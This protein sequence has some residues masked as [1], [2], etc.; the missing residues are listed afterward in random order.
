MFVR[1]KDV[2]PRK[3]NDLVLERVMLPRNESRGKNVEAVHWTLQP[4]GV[5]TI[6]LVERREGAFYVISGRGLLQSKGGQATRGVTLYSDMAFWFAKGEFVMSNKGE[7]EMRIIM[8]TSTVD[9]DHYEFTRPRMQY[10]HSAPLRLQAGYVARAM[11][12]TQEIATCGGL[13]TH[14]MEVETLS[15]NYEAAIHIDPEEVLYVL[16]GEGEMETGG[17]REEIGPGTLV[18]SPDH[19]P[20]GLW[21]KSNVDNMEYMVIEFNELSKRFAPML[22]DVKR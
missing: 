14:A 4:G 7:G 3:I 12:S 5:F 9:R 11:F 13:R 21:N 19:T 18:Y 17:K 15:P 1:V 22:S 6:P 20:H 8:V 16:R 10:F 2:S